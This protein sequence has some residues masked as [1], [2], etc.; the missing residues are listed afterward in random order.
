[1]APGPGRVPLQVRRPEGAS[2]GGV[3]LPARRRPVD[4]LLI[5]G[6]VLVGLVLGWNVLTI[7]MA[8]RLAKGR[9]EAALGWRQG[10][11]GALVTLAERS[12]NGGDLAAAE[13]FARAALKTD[14]M[15]VPAT[16]VL[17]LA[18]DRRGDL[19]LADRLMDS[20]GARSNRDPAVQMWLFARTSAK[21]DFGR[22]FARADALIRDEPD[23]ARRFYPVMSDMARRPEAIGPLAA[24]LKTNPPWRDSFVQAYIRQSADPAD[25]YLLIEGLEAAGAPPSP[26]ERQALL[27]RLVQ[28]RRFQQAFLFWVQGL[29]KADLENLTDVFDGGFEGSTA[30]GPFNWTIE[31][32]AQGFVDFEAAPGREDRALH[33]VFH[34]AAAPGSLVRQL[35]VLPPGRHVLRGEVRADAFDA[36]GG[37]VWSIR[38]AGPAGALLAET[39]LLTGSAPWRRFEVAF[40]VPPGC[41]AQWLRLRPGARGSRRMSGE[42]W[43]DNLSVTRG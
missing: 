5:A 21:G 24:R 37:P 30:P 26:V 28:D 4:L 43:Y 39:P 32:A 7:A 9:P 1:M 19:A 18:A 25:P 20:A 34:G 27:G 15:E 40:T 8:D 23:L 14:P 13:T 29:S 33:L 6:L 35:L 31:R 41:D 22:A 3:R 2:D 17:G 38:C 42:V 12:L 10:H 36:A 11:A 16:R